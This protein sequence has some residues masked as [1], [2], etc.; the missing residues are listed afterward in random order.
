MTFFKIIL[1][2]YYNQKYLIRYK[3]I[4]SLQD[5]LIVVFIFYQ[6]YVPTELPTFRSY[7][8]K[9]VNTTVVKCR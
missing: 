7:G 8:T 5:L 9:K 3:K 4:P 6:Y 1:L 2:K